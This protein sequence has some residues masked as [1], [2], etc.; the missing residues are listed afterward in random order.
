LLGS[1]SAEDIQRVVDLA[2]P[3]ITE[4]QAAYDAANTAFN[5]ITSD[6]N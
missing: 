5:K 2:G 1:N 4:F 3:A 6:G